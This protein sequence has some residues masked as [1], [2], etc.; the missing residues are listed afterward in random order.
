[1]S[2]RSALSGAVLHATD[3][4]VSAWRHHHP[5]RGVAH[6]RRPGD[7]VGLVG[8]NGV[9]KSHPAARP[10]RRASCPTRGRGRARPRPPPPSASSPRSPTP[11]RAR[12]CSTTWPAARAWPRPPTTLDR[13]T[14]AAL[15]WRAGR[16][17]RVHRRA[18]AL[19]G[20]RRRR[21]RRPGRRGAAPTVG[22][23]RRRRL[24]GSEV[25]TLSG[26]RGG[27]GRAGRHPAVAGSTCCLL[28]EPTNNLDFAGLD[29]LER[30]V[31]GG[32]RGRGGGLARPGL[33]RP[34]RHR[35]VEIDEHSH[36]AREFAGGWSDYIAGRDLARRQQPRAHGKYAGRAGSA[37]ASG[38]A[39]RRSG[40]RP[41]CAEGQDDERADKIIAPPP[42]SPAPRSRRRR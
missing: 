42:G 29:L 19:P 23:R 31:D 5:R 38:S 11:T 27:P 15:P 13:R 2:R 18:R 6:G 22:L 3:V 39:P 14:A 16:R 20:P 9:G 10:R 35:V 8:P 4:T 21:L 28:D 24:L 7:R 33:P 40:A 12:R 17:R 36:R 25:A 37:R 34:R 30:F 1:M 32:R 41:G 26:G